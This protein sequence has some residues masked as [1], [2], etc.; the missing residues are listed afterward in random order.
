MQTSLWGR[1]NQIL[2]VRNIIIG[3]VT[4]LNGDG[5][6]TVITPE[7]FTYR[8]RG[9]SVAP[10]LKAYIRDGRIQGVAP[11]LPVTNVTV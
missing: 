3:S 5:T 2:P 6:S 11:S 9:Q 1:F 7:G 4:A 10:G 8:V